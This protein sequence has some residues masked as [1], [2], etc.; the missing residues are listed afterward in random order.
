MHH[1]TITVNSQ[2]GV[3]SRFTVSLPLQREIFEEDVQVE[4]IL[5]DSQSSAPHPVDSMKAPEEV[6]EKEDLE[7][8]SDG[9]SILVVEDNEELKRL[10]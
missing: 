5:N 9:F 10:F 1:G 6:E 3:G 7:T 2:P 8:N 4:F